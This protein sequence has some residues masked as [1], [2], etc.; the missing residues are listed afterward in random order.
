MKSSGP[1]E[2]VLTVHAIQLGDRI[3][4]SGIEGE[5]LSTVPLAI[6]IDKAG[7]AVLFRYGVV[8]LIGLSPQQEQ[9]FLEKLSIRVSGRFDRLRKKPRS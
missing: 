8:V 5:T 2:Q 6:R 7:I 1:N 3:N 9:E 4:T